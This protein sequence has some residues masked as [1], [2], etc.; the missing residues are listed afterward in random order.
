MIRLLC[1]ELKDRGNT[2]IRVTLPQSHEI[3]VV[4]EVVI[5]CDID[6]PYGFLERV[7]DAFPGLG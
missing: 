7:T 3:S 1:R 2:S 5:L 4:C 6:L